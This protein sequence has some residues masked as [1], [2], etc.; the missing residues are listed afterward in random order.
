MWPYPKVLAH[1]GAGKLAPENTLAALRCGLALGF[2]AV[3]FDVM[4]SKD[5]VPVL[6]HDPEFGRTVAGSGLVAGTNA[7]DLLTMDAGSWLD[8]RFQGEPVPSYEQVIHFCREQ[9]IWMNVEI[10]PSPGHE[11]V[12]GR[13]VAALSA[14]CFADVVSSDPARLPLLSSF[15]VTA[16]RAAKTAAPQIP[17]ALLLDSPHPDWKSMLQ[18]L[19][20]VALHVNHKHLSQEWAARVKNAG[21][22]LF[23]YT[24]NEP[25]RAHELLRWGVDAFCTD[26]PDRIPADF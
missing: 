7:A 16:L 19:S 22:G 15:S 11:E 8:A 24:V 1:R 3:E 17:R 13:I 23:C 2:H 26:Y 6:M 9:Q 21:Y 18:E 20:A 10:K 25:E 5:S 14:A 4:L 12:T